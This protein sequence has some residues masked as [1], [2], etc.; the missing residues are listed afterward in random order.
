MG[1]EL[2]GTKVTGTNKCRCSYVHVSINRWMQ[3]QSC[4]L[5]SIYVEELSSDSYWEQ[6]A[7]GFV[8]ARWILDGLMI[9]LIWK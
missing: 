1:L 2:D 6:N 8:S 7:A 3:L 4:S 9:A 5:Q